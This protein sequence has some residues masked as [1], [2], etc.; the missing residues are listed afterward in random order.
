MQWNAPQA[1]ASAGAP[2]A[3][4]VASPH[5][6]L[7][8]GGTGTWEIDLAH[9]TVHA[10]VP[11]RRL[12][13]LPGRGPLPIGKVRA[14]LAPGA[15]IDAGLAALRAGGGVSGELRV[16]LADGTSRC[17]L[18]RGAA[19]TPQS[20]SPA[21]AVGTATDVTDLRT[22]LR[23]AEA[24]S[25]RAQAAETALLAELAQARKLETLG[26]LTS[27]VAH[28]L[29][30]TLTAI[31]NAFWLI[32]RRSDDPRIRRITAQGT[33]AADRAS[34]LVRRLL[35]FARKERPEDVPVDAARLLIDAE[36]ILRHAAG[37]RVALAVTV[38]HGTSPVMADPRRLEAALINLVVNAR[39]AMPHGGA[40]SLDIGNASGAGNA[41]Q[42]AFA[43]RDSGCGMSAEV[44]ARATEPFFTTKGQGAGTGLGLAMVRSLADRSGGT[45]R[46]ESRSGAGT[47]A[48]LSLPAASVPDTQPASPAEAPDPAPRAAGR[49][50]VVDDDA[51]VRTLT[52]ECLRDL[53]CVVLEA[54]SGAAGL[55]IART[56]ASLDLVV[57]DLAMPGMDGPTLELRVRTMHPALPV[58]FMSGDHDAAHLLPGETLL[59]KPFTAAA[60]AEA[61][62]RKLGPPA[63]PPD[64]LLARL[65]DRRLRAAYSAWLGAGARTRLPS[66][67]AIDPAAFDAAE[68]AAL[69]E[70]DPA[71]NPVDFRFVRVG[72]S[73]EA[74]L[75][76]RLAG[77]RIQAHAGEALGSLSGAAIR[78]ARTLQPG[79]ERT[80]FDLG[81][82]APSSL[83]RLMLPLSRTGAG[84][85]HLLSVAIFDPGLRGAMRWPETL[86]D[87]DAPDLA[88]A[89]AA[90][91]Q[92]QIDALPF[93]AILVDNAGQ[94][95]FYSRAERR[96]SG[97][98]ERPRLGR[99]FFTD[100]APC[101]AG[102][103]FRG[104]I[105]AALRRGTLDLEFEHTGDFDDP[106]RVLARPRPV[107]RAGGF[108]I[109][110]A[111]P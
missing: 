103:E 32:D 104:R 40:I 69:I 44:L 59:R 34:H 30:N 46:L 28:D 79:Y 53:G 95:Q 66:P 64:K 98:G 27:G 45:L 52:A 99:A 74:R 33:H 15:A 80:R 38:R 10:S 88:Q 25:R 82:G 73:L 5:E 101:M 36:P 94:V 71:A 35:D 85:T 90:L 49:I 65:R 21:R 78:C 24:R 18:L 61:V 23:A 70:V 1:A 17:I 107:G 8:A 3:R 86:P 76:R 106:D 96:L 9:G 43:V 83:E 105:E 72:R 91:T 47:L 48:T 29:N 41:A 93:G 54:E 109:F 75:G 89:V 22:R 13:G 26:A 2:G 62:A 100:I 68:H 31:I 20:G 63:A 37:P 67:D 81:D 51:D 92:D 55:A 77:E 111:R 39:D 6:A 16:R 102:P 84:I 110:M 87:F 12:C 58:L 50:L 56:E 42:V 60:L 57:A 14:Q 11:M 19:L 7:A 108:W 4:D 97:S